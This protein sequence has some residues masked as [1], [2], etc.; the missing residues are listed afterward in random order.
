MDG[1]SPSAKLAR[2][3][4]TLT[5]LP[6]G[7]LVGNAGDLLSTVNLPEGWSWLS[8]NDI[9]GS[10]DKYSVVFTNSNVIQYRRESSYLLH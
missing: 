3:T 6:N 7:G 2:E 8:P 10:R 1:V 9:V 5:V 4:A